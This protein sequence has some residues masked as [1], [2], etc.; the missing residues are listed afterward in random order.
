MARHPRHDCTG[1]EKKDTR[2]ATLLEV[3]SQKITLQHLIGG[4]SRALI[5]HR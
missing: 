4:R 2:S 5:C 3:A 1:V